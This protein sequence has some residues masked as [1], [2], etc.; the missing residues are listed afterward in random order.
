MYFR[1]RTIRKNAKENQLVA[2]L[3]DGFWHCI[4]TKRDKDNLED[5]IKFRK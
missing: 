3:H 5:D 1:K 2:F 4:D